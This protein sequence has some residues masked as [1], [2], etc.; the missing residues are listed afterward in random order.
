METKKGADSLEHW[1]CRNGFPATAIHGDRTQQ[2]IRELSRFLAFTCSSFDNTFKHNQ[3]LKFKEGNSLR[4]EIERKRLEMEKDK[5]KYV[6]RKS[7][8]CRRSFSS[9]DRYIY[10]CT[11]TYM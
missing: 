10:R 9:Y 6:I 11:V 2:V 7:K 5:K 3:S 8:L 1:L 4:K